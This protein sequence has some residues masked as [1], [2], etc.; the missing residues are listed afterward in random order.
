MGRGR[1]GWRGGGGGGRGWRMEEEE[2]DGERGRGG[3]WREEDGERRVQRIA[4]LV[5]FV[6]TCHRGVMLLSRQHP[7]PCFFMLNITV[8]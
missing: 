2:E 8:L 7:M 1:G 3:G 4:T 6:A 5:C